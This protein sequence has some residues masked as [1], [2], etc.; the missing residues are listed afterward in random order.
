[1]KLYSKVDYLKYIKAPDCDDYL[2][3]ILADCF[4]NIKST[5][6][7]HTLDTILK[8]KISLDEKSRDT[9]E[10]AMW[11]GC[12]QVLSKEFDTLAYSEVAQCFGYIVVENPRFG[13]CRQTIMTFMIDIASGNLSSEIHYT[14][15]YFSLIY[16]WLRRDLLI[17]SAVRN[18]FNQDYT[19]DVVEDIKK[20]LSVFTQYFGSTLCLPDFMTAFKNTSWK[21]TLYELCYDSDKYKQWSSWKNSWKEFT[22]KNYFEWTEIDDLHWERVQE[23]T[24]EYIDSQLELINTFDV[25]EIYYFYELSL[26]S[27]CHSLMKEQRIENFVN[28]FMERIKPMAESDCEEFSYITEVYNGLKSLTEQ[29]DGYQISDIENIIGYNI[30]FGDCRYYI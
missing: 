17:Y 19:D 30:C 22:G 4:E 12:T 28:K 1:M 6:Q 26:F 8:F 21:P 27:L 5:V 20:R 3:S 7:P 18:A 2:G 9:E 24:E 10:Q 11:N 14:G 29:A 15:E 25:T 13:L 23:A 16:D